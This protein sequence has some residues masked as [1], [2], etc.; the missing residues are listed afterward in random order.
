M[1]DKQKAKAPDTVRGRKQGA[2]AA[3]QRFLPVAEIRNDIILLKNGGL[4]AVLEVE[5]MNFNLKSETEQQGIIAGY[6]AFVNTLEFPV[7][8]VIRSS[9]TNIDDYLEAIR[10]I[11][12]KHTNQL[13]KNQTLGYVGFMQKLLEVADIMQKRFYIVVPIDHSIRKKTIVEQFFDWL[14]PDDSSSKAGQRYRE[15]AQNARQ[16][17]ERVDLVS[18]GLSNIGLHT[19]RMNTR[20]LID[21]LYKIYNPKTSQVQ[22]LPKDGANL[23][24]ETTTL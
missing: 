20:D 15:F 13:L 16:I 1:A 9:R 5:A 11:G 24:L 7:Q 22:K 19:R 12:E 21:L 18:T 10:E 23:N 3:T 6:G 17:Q 4:R 2:G 8:I 14:H